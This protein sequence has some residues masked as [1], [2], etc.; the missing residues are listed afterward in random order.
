MQWVVVSYM[1]DNEEAASILNVF[2]PFESR[3]E[4]HKWGMEFADEMHAVMPIETP[5]ERK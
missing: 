4:A 1:P 5:F 3:D 2:G